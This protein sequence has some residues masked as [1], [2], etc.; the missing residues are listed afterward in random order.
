MLHV[1]MWVP[2]TRESLEAVV[3]GLARQNVYQL[4]ALAR[5]GIVLPKLYAST[6][7]YR[8]EPP[9]K[10]HWRSLARL[11]RLEPSYPTGKLER[12]GDCEDLAAL[13]VA[14]HRFYD[15]SPSRVQVYQTKTSGLLHA[16]VR[17]ADGSLED[18]TRV[19]KGLGR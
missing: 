5:R 18:P 1:E 17:R 14:E 4:E 10:E 16:I 15:H 13:V 19:L 12:W 11:Y 7:V 6:I 2:A 9:G 8:E 3:E